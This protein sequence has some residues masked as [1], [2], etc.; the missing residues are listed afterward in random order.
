MRKIN[1]LF[2]LGLFLYVSLG[3]SAYSFSAK[4]EDGVTIYYTITSST[5]CEVTYESEFY[6]QIFS[7][8]RGIINIPVSVKRNSKTYTVTSI[9]HSAFYECYDLTSVTIGDSVTSI[10]KN[11]FYRCG[12]LT[13]VMI[14]NSVT[15]IGSFAFMECGL[16]SL[17]I[18]NSV[19]SI[20]GGAFCDCKNVENLY[21]D[22]DVSPRCIT[23]YCNLKLKI[24]TIGN[25][26]TSI[27][28]EAFRGCRSLTSINIPNAVTSIGSYAF[29][30]CSSLE[31]VYVSWNRPIS[32][33]GNVF[34]INKSGYI[35][36]TLYV[37]QGK[38]A[39]YKAADVWNKF[40]DIVQEQKAT[41]I[42]IDKEKY[43]CSVG[44][45]GQATTT[46]SPDDATIK[47]VKWASSNPEKLYIDANTG[48]FRGL[49]TGE[50][51]ITA[52]TTDGTNLSDTSIVII[53]QLAQSIT[54][55]KEKYECFVG[56][57]GK[58][59][60]TVKPTDTSLKAVKWTSSSPEKL[61]I[62]ENTG[63]FKGLASGSVLITVTTTDGTQLSDTATIIIKQLVK[64]VTIGKDEYECIVGETG[65]ATAT[66]KPDDATTKTVKWTSSNPTKLSIDENTGEFKG[67]ATGAVIITATATDGSG[68]SDQAIVVVQEP[69]GIEEI[70]T[71]RINAKDA[72]FDLQGKRVEH[73][74]QGNVYIKS[75]KKF[76]AK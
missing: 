72:I 41:S 38:L 22:S 35:F 40:V 49:A 58:A 6:G 24:V 11:A 13:S 8:Y 29:S 59:T 16:T 12:K 37:P 9:G 28:D 4:N 50:V 70:S 75:E 63:E 54:I 60:A 64:S 61:S 47:T 48:E 1:F 53:R 69:S 52:R 26:V 73:M 25:S 23:Q 31:S 2:M 62:D 19:T 10:G 51:T 57:V 39:I 34:D 7:N 21:W 46:I 74:K 15:S 55:D 43:Q 3:A 67:L 5:T 36:S 76:I 42:K 71:D 27:E 45:M 68:V 44:E 17:T 66:V 56:D 18:K 20:E 32:I 30:G 14:P 33:S 65:Q